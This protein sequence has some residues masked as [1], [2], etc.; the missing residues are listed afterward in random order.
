[1]SAGRPKKVDPGTLYSFAHQ[2]YWDFRR[3]SEGRRRW[4]VNKARYDQLTKEIDNMRLIDDEDRMRHEKMIDEEIQTGRLAPSQREEKLRD[5]Q[6]VELSVK[7]QF[8]EEQALFEAQQ[9]I[10]IPGER[11]VIDVLLNP[12]TTPAEIRELCKE[13]IMT[14]T[15]QIRPG[16][17]HEVEVPAWPIQLGSTLPTY[18]SEYAEQYIL[19]L[20]DPRFPSCDMS[21]RPSTRLKQF[22]FLSRA[23]AGALYGVK[24]RTAINLVGSLRPEEVF[25]ESRD[26]KPARTRVRRKYKRRTE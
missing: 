4:R 5:I 8:Y 11:D 6:E 12:N 14:R 19:A 24:T 15:V 13:A 10:R 25:N 9:E 7:R 26:A 1:M 16:L 21:A 3:L 20:N 22:W 18:L 2:F 23:L 17:H